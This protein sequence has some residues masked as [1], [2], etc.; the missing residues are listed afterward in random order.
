MDRERLCLSHMQKG[1]YYV[2]IYDKYCFKYYVD[3]KNG[4]EIY[5]IKHSEYL[6]I[7]PE[8]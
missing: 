6:N 8:I 4:A 3:N 2:Q 1:T 7:H 5:K